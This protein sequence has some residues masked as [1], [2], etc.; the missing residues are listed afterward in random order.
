[1][2][3]T[4]IERYKVDPADVPSADWGW[5]KIT[6]RTWYA[7][8]IF[9]VVFLLGMMHGNHIGHVENWFLLAFAVLTAGAIVRDWWLRRRKI[10]R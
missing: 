1:M 2:V 3:S 10:L 9:I 4:D 8:G 7:V 5:S 6:H